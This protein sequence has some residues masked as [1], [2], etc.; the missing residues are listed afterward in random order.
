MAQLDKAQF[1]PWALITDASSG[2]G[3]DTAGR[4]LLA[5]MH[6]AGAWFTAKGIAM[7]ALIEE[8]TGEQPLHLSGAKQPRRSKFAS[9]TK[10]PK[11]ENN[12]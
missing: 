3:V 12:K 6:R 8:I 2:I 11:Q 9:T 10:S 5:A 7:T 4:A 1:G